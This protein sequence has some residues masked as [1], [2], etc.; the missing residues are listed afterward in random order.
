MTDIRADTHHIPKSQLINDAIVASPKVVFGVII[1]KALR[2]EI[3]A[4]RGWLRAPACVDP[5][6]P[7]SQFEVITNEIQWERRTTGL[8]RA[9]LNPY[10]YF[11]IAATRFAIGLFIGGALALG[12]LGYFIFVHYGL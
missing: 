1:S 8:K 6:F 7:P 9:D 2:D 10:S 11:E 4:T 5:R 12:I 3:R